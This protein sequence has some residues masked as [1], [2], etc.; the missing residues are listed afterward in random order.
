M[1][2]I[3]KDNRHRATSS[4]L[5]AK[6]KRSSS[7]LPIFCEPVIRARAV[8]SETLST[9]I[10]GPTGNYSLTG[11]PIETFHGRLDRASAKRR[12]RHTFLIL[13]VLYDPFRSQLIKARVWG[14][15]AARFAQRSKMDCA[16]RHVMTSDGPRRSCRCAGTIHF[17]AVIRRGT[18]PP[19]R[20]RFLSA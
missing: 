5:R 19:L 11:T 15:G 14:R 1:S 4:R 13:H 20:E 2:S 16:R 6:L 9:Q 8:A 7:A 3:L 12:Y 10:S 18:S 17:C